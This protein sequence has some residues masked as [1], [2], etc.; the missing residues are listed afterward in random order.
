[1]SKGLPLPG[2]LLEARLRRLSAVTRR[3]VGIRD[4]TSRV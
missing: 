3:G 1:M 2:R 4:P